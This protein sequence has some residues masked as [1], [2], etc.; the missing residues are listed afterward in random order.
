M[1]LDLREQL[2]QA[3]PDLA[4]Q[5]V[6][7]GDGRLPPEYNT[8]TIPETLDKFCAD[9]LPRSPLIDP[10]GSQF[11]LVKGNF[12]KL[13]DLKHKLGRDEYKASRIIRDIEDGR[14]DKQDYCDMDES[15]IRT[16]FW[17]PSVICDPDA[18][19]R[20]GHKIVAGDRVYARVYKKM[21]SRI[22]LVFTMDVK[23]KKE[24]FMVPVTSFLTDP[25]T[26]VKCVK[27]LPLYQKH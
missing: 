17:L 16:L 1:G 13:V 24:Q 22:K 12:A 26:A 23:T 5:G 18:I 27:G 8:L 15:R 20:N 7:F 25:E 2:M 11:R 6:F 19:Y 14:F 4:H 3:V 10:L 21:G 9:L